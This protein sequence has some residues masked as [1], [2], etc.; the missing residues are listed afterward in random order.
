[1]KFR[2][3][4]KSIELTGQKERLLMLLM[5]RKD[6][7]RDDV[8]GVLWPEP[9]FL[10]ENLYHTAHSVM[11]QLRRRIEPLGWTVKHPYFLGNYYLEKYH[12]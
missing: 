12:G 5:A 4:G 3:N 10:A 7:N 11:L 9:E 1:M 2:G 8:L 6:V